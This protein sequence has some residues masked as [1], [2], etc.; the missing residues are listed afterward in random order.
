MPGVLAWAGV[1][2]LAGLG[3]CRGDIADPFDAGAGTSTS[4]EGGSSS[5]AEGDATSGR[6]A[7][8]TGSADTTG[9]EDGDS[10]EI[11]YDVGT[12]SDAPTVETC[13]CGNDEWSYLWVANSDSTVS[14]INT[15]DLVEE[16]RYRT[17]A[18]YGSPSRTS[19][20]IDGQA[21]V[22]ANRMEASMIKVW[23][24][25]E[26]CED[27]NGDGVITT[28]VG[29]ADVKGWSGGQP[30]DECIAWVLEFPGMT[31][32]R[33]VQW[34]SGTLD[35]VTC[36]YV[37]QKIWTV[38]LNESAGPGEDMTFVH[39]VD[40]DTGTI[41]TTIPV[42]RAQWESE[43]FDSYHGAYGGA[44]DAD[45]NFYFHRHFPDLVG[46]V[47]FATMELETLGDPNGFGGG[48]NAGYGI[49]VD[50][51]GRVWFAGQAGRLDFDAAAMTDMPGND[52]SSLGGL[53]EDHQ[54]RMW[55]PYESDDYTQSGVFWVDLETLAMG[56]VVVLDETDDVNGPSTVKGVSVDIDGYIWG[57]PRNG[58]AYRIDPDT[59]EVEVVGGLDSPYT[60]S[61]M[62]GGQL[63]TI[64][65]GTPAG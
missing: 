55:M 33:P 15:R 23:A 30:D 20:S 63:A 19:V 51:Q 37:D 36:E 45:N 47:T 31:E 54:G 52:P 35:P 28:S 29:P 56:D 57:V 1:L 17:S 38:T 16:G 32:E 53:A 59:Y 50:T 62:T 41:D 10:G 2:G 39:L 21:M 24:R 26:L 9:A 12:V 40:G 60:Y 11:I 8:G 43:D 65:C 44:V 48:L 46:R 6:D 18:S 3:G 49:T 58:N 7:T 34:T 22:V 13:G 14:K 25:P 42:P 5:S 64:N 27:K 4:A 61:D